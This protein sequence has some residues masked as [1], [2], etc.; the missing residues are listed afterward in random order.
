MRYVYPEV[1]KPGN[2]A[3]LLHLF[4]FTYNP[5]PIQV[6]PIPFNVVFWSISTEFQFYLIVPFIYAIFKRYFQKQRYI[7]LAI[8]VTI[9]TIFSLK[10]AI[11]IAL[12]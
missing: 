5:R 2:W 12:Y 1:L 11:W 10:F 3:V 8:L 6:P 7:Y 9:L 4:T